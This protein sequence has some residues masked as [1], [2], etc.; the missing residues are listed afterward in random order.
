MDIKAAYLPQAERIIEADN[1]YSHP[2]AGRDSVRLAYILY[3][4]D[5]NADL[6]DEAVNN[7]RNGG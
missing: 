4:E 7:W 3:A 2:I 1:D 5:G 6:W